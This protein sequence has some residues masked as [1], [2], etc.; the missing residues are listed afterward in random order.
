ML[1]RGLY[2]LND[3]LKHRKKLYG[4]SQGD[5]LESILNR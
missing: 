5:R 4:L 1:Q 3:M 2:T